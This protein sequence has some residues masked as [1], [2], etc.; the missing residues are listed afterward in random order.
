MRQAKLYY[1]FGTELH[2]VNRMK[3]YLQ[4]VKLRI[5]FSTDVYGENII[6]TGSYSP[7]KNANID[8]YH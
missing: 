7:F 3:E 5:A 4:N 1:L 8:P 6:A 2:E